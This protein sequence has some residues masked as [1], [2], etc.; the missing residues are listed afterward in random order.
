LADIILDQLEE[1]QGKII[2]CFQDTA[3]KLQGLTDLPMI[4]LPEQ[5]G[6][7]RKPSITV[8]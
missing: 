6:S 1:T 5:E 4:I 2:F 7:E 3:E 8:R